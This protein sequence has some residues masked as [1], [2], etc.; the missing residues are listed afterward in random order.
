[1]TQ[2]IALATGFWGNRAMA[3]PLKEALSNQFNV[4]VAD[5]GFREVME[6]S[7][8][9]RFR[10]AAQN[11]LV[12]TTSAGHLALTKTVNPAGV[13][14]YGAP[15]PRHMAGLMARSAAITAEHIVG[16]LPNQPHPSG[17]RHFLAALRH[18]VAVPHRAWGNLRHLG[19]VA[20]HHAFARAAAM[21]SAG[22]PNMLVYTDKDRYFSPQPTDYTLAASLAIPVHMR[23]GYHNEILTD[24]ASM[25]ADLDIEDALASIAEGF[26]PEFPM[27]ND[28]AATLE[29]G[30]DATVQALA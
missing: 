8:H 18:E 16:S 22:I 2:H 12:I 17:D 30:P 27:P 5:F 20:R 13:I 26:Y 25:L 14:A 1:M 7:G 10:K 23:P 21:Q 15:I 24:P 29:S 4:D 11:S 28:R 19:T 3:E 9:E 6:E